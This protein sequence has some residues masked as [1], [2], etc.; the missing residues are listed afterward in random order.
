[1]VSAEGKVEW[2]ASLGGGFSWVED[3]TVDDRGG[4]HALGRDATGQGWLS[5]LGPDGGLTR[6]TQVPAGEFVAFDVIG[7]HVSLFVAHPFSDD[8]DAPTHTWVR[9]DCSHPQR[10]FEVRTGVLGYHSAESTF[11]IVPLGNDLVE[12]DGEVHRLSNGT[13]ASLFVADAL[14]DNEDL[15][16]LPDDGPELD[17]VEILAD[18][19]HRIAVGS[20][21]VV[22]AQRSGDMPAFLTFGDSGETSERIA[23]SFI[24]ASPPLRLPRDAAEGDWM[25]EYAMHGTPAVSHV[26]TFRAQL[27]PDQCNPTVYQTD[28]DQIFSLYVVPEYFAP[29]DPCWWHEESRAY[30]DEVDETTFASEFDD[31]MEY[32]G[33]TYSTGK[34]LGG[35]GDGFAQR[36]EGHLRSAIIETAIDLGQAEG[37]MQHLIYTFA[38]DDASA[39]GFTALGA[40]DEAE[41]R[42]VAA[43]IVE[44]L[45]AD[46]DYCEELVQLGAYVDTSWE[47]DFT[48]ECDLLYALCVGNPE[49]IEGR[50]TPA[51]GILYER[52]CDEE[53]EAY[54]WE[55]TP[56]RWRSDAIEI[57]VSPAIAASCGNDEALLSHRYSCGV[58]VELSAHEFEFS[59]SPTGEL[60]LTRIEILETTGS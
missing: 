12:V 6:T 43:T 33:E 2:R 19:L 40:L 25:W 22:V 39:D 3:V 9:G 1:M 57:D 34:Q 49:D 36:I 41:A 48:N 20:H 42:R 38:D 51:S 52:T 8:D 37:L 45:Q 23:R 14:D 30:L 10:E 17:V 4:L 27:P 13:T 46:N 24:A 15:G 11:D 21:R 5:T 59:T 31:W 32:L 47:V 26:D 50:I 55:C 16:D 28:C 18:E 58:S 7:E 53:A 44:D 56:D 54:D 29:G 60:R 35:P